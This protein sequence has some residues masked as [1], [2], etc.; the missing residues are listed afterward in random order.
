MREGGGNIKNYPLPAEEATALQQLQAS[1][2]SKPTQVILFSDPNKDP[3]DLATYV[4]ASGLAKLGHA[5]VLSIVTTLGSL[6]TRRLRAR[7]AKGALSALGLDSISVAVGSE[8]P[9]N[10]VQEREHNEFL[11]GAGFLASPEQVET[12]ALQTLVSQLRRAPNSSVTLTII[13]GMTDATQLLE[14]HPRLVQEKVCRVVIMGGIESQL[15]QGLVVPDQQS[16]NS[17]TDYPA[18]QAFYQRVQELGIEL[19]IVT[20]EAAY[21]ASI[22]PKFYEQLAASGHP[23]TNYLAYCQY[24]ALEGLWQALGGTGAQSLI[25]GRDL[26]WF[27][28]TFTDL[29]AGTHLI[30]KLVLDG[31][32]EVWQQ[33]TKLYLYDPIAYLAS[34]S[35]APSLFRS[36][37]ITPGVQLIGAKEVIDGDRLRSTL[38]TLAKLACDR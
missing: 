22:T 25:P 38:F 36:Q 27:I 30:E 4:V 5:Q 31:F 10:A 11:L 6:E 14:T 33:V 8:Y 12:D 21:A 7:F 9:R 15:S 34:T 17:L 20:K 24:Q 3:D 2:P 16:Y 37:E 19:T 26:P 23:V 13:A 29:E 32:S 1:Q 35:I 28:D 18:A